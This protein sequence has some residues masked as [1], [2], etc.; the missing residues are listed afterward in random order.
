MTFGWL[1]PGRLFVFAT[2][3]PVTFDPRLQLDHVGPRYGWTLPILR[4]HRLRYR[5][6]VTLF[7]LLDGGRLRRLPVVIRLPL[8]ADVTRVD[9][10][11]VGPGRC[12]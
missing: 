12:D 7:D 3:A 9:V 8:P 10:V 6:Y 5:C 1:L 2:T 4:L 11:T